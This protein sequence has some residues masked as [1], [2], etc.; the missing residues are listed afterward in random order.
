[1]YKVPSFFDQE[2]HILVL[3]KCVSEHNAWVPRLYDSVNTAQV[4]R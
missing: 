2:Q 3:R 4:A 1:M